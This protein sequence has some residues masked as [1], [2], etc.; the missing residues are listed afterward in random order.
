[1]TPPP[2]ASR[3]RRH[4]RAL[5]VAALWIFGIVLARLLPVALLVGALA[6]LGWLR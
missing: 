5:E 2:S 3:P 6:M 4:S 1:M